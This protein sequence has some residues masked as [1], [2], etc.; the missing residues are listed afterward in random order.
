MTQAEAGTDQCVDLSL[1]VRCWPSRHLYTSHTQ[2][3]STSLT[4][5]NTRQPLTINYV[6]STSNG[7]H[8]MQYTAK[9]TAEE[10]N[11][12]LVVS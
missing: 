1:T 5:Y 9:Q 6:S 12:Q 8:M 3:F 11:R 4:S 2:Q 10:T 7:T